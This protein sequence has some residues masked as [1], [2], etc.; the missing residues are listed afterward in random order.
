VD[1]SYIMPFIKSI[2]N[3]FDTMLQLPVEVQEPQ[4]KSSDHPS[5]DVSGII[6]MSG[7][8]EGS[9]VLSFPTTTAER[10]VSLFTGMD[11]AHSHE[12][13]PDA[14]GE[15]VNM[16]SGGAKAQFADK[17]VNITC[18]SVVLGSD[19]LVYSR[20]DV[21]CICIPCTCHCGNF[22]VDIALRQSNPDN[23]TNHDNAVAN[24]SA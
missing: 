1:S 4:L 8:V 9:I 17:K 7:D 23:A 5:Y 21:V 3:V 22:S 12:D 20:K 18:P 19:H 13:F 24:A 2:Q 11:I 15:L 14:I 6:G 10:V 16:I